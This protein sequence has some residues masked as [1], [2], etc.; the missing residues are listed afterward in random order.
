MSKDA[1]DSFPF[2]V[3]G[4]LIVT[5]QQ[6]DNEKEAWDS[7]Y[8]EAEQS[9]RWVMGYKIWR[10]IP[11][12]ARLGEELYIVSARVIALETLPDGLEEAHI[13]GPY[14]ELED[15]GAIE[16]GTIGYELTEMYD[17]TYAN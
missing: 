10:T 7:F 1:I 4:H 11:K 5:G 16:Y 15:P 6:S 13:Y 9:F 3:T 17:H 2:I 12:C 14:P 8:A